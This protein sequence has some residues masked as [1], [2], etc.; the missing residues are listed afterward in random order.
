MLT[1]AAAAEPSASAV[2]TA[3][4]RPLALA[5]GETG[6]VRRF[7]AWRQRADAEER[8]EAASARARAYLYSDLPANERAEAEL[9]LAAVLDDPSAVARRALAEALAGAS[10]APRA[11]VLGL[12]A[13]QSDVASVVLGRSPLLTEAELVD[14]VAVGDAAAQ[15]AI[16]HRPRLPVGVAAALAEVG[17][18]EAAIALADN[19]EANVRPSA[20][21]RLFE[22]FSEDAEVRDALASRPHLPAA[23]RNELAAATARALA[24]FSARCGWLTAERAQRIARDA[25]EQ[26]TA[27]IVSGARGDEL[28]ELARR[29]RA[30]GGLTVAM[31]MRALLCGDREFFAQ[32]LSE[33]SGLASHRAAALARA[34][35]GQGFAALYAKARLP[36]AFL[37][38]FR[39]ALAALDAVD[40]PRGETLSRT[41]CERVIAACE[42][43]GEVEQ[44]PM[45]ALLWRFA[46]EAARASAREYAEDAW[47]A[48]PPLERPNY[49]PL[50]LEAVAAALEESDPPP[51]EPPALLESPFAPFAPLVEPTLAE[52]EDEASAAP[53]VQLP[54]DM[55]AALAEAA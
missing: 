28:A 37:T 44:G 50:L 30:S 45:L 38:A 52:L 33:L 31:L 18:R 32:A 2:A 6:I 13:D 25:R 43:R 39:A 46:S 15:T 47:R 40:P 26:A 49:A 5:A 34:P 16:A 54:A 42:G 1:L 9:G 23:L 10:E 48:P 53:P 20:L 19:L 7:L 11:V 21:W 8:A 4:E 27:T 55:L 22:R 14:F 29:M 3:A 24:D 51:V 12:A 36:D 41:L 35:K 17:R